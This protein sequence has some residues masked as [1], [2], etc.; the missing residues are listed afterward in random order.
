[1]GKFIKFA[2]LWLSLSFISSVA[3]ATTSV[4]TAELN[5]EECDTLE[6]VV[7]CS[8]HGKRS[9]SLSPATQKF[10]KEHKKKY[11]QTSTKFLVIF[12]AVNKVIFSH[13]KTPIYTCFEQAKTKIDK[14]LCFKKYS[15]IA[16]DTFCK[17]TQAP[18][19]QG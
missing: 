4:P 11:D 19:P 7:T 16:H 9:E 18:N 8:T 13:Y 12:I 6:F 17:S 3:L 15:Q 5:G 2:T 10:C 14:V 1:M